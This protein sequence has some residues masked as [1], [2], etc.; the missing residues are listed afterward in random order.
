M[1]SLILFFS[2]G[3]TTSFHTLTGDHRQTILKLDVDLPNKHGR[4]G[5]SKNRFA[6]IRE[7][8]RNVYTTKIAALATTHFIDPAN[9][10]PSVNGM[11]IAGS[12]HLKDDVHKKLD[13]RLFKIVLSVVDVQYGGEAGFNQ[14]INLSMG[15]LSNLKVVREQE[16]LGKYFD[17]I[18]RDGNYCFGVEDTL[19]GVTSG[20]VETL[21][22]YKELPH[23]RYELE[24]NDE[25][26]VVFCSPG[27]KLVEDGEWQVISCEPLVDWILEH[28]KEFGVVIELVSNQTSIGSQFVKGF[29]GIGGFLRY[30]TALPSTGVEPEEEDFVW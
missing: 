6:R 13:P 5:Q 8:K 2:D 17:E 11:V 12:A 1:P 24:M 25:K 29:G 15:N 7:E 3:H 16:V 30:E 10:L 9:S 27:S 26:K 14:A 22:L 20:L 28:Y 18:A 4:G 21:I 19:Y 23:L